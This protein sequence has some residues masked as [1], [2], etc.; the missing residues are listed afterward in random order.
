MF[1]NILHAPTPIKRWGWP[2]HGFWV[3]TQASEYKLIIAGH[4]IS[5]PSWFAGWPAGRRYGLT[6]KHPDAPPLAMSAAEKQ[7]EADQNRVWA[8]FAMLAGR[9]NWMYANNQ[10]GK[11]SWIATLPDNKAWRVGLLPFNDAGNWV[12][13]MQFY[14]WTDGPLD[15]GTGGFRY[16]AINAKGANNQNELFTPATA[17]AAYTAGDTYYRI[18]DIS[19]FGRRAVVNKSPE[20]WRSAAVIRIP[21]ATEFAAMGIDL[22]D[23]DGWYPAAVFDP[24]VDNVFSYEELGTPP[25]S[26]KLESAMV[27]ESFVVNDIDIVNNPPVFNDAIITV[28][29]EG[30]SYE[31]VMAYVPVLPEVKCKVTCQMARKAHLSDSDDTIVFYR[32]KTEITGY[33]ELIGGGIQ[34]VVSGSYRI[35]ENALATGVREIF[36]VT[37]TI[38]YGDA[39]WTASS[40]VVYEYSTNNPAS[41]YREVDG[42]YSVR[43]LVPGF[44]A[45]ETM[46]R[47]APEDSG[48]AYDFST[49]QPFTSDQGR[50]EQFGCPLM[51][52]PPLNEDATLHA[53]KWAP[54][55]LEIPQ[56][57]Y[58]RGRFI[59]AWLPSSNYAWAFNPATN[60]L[61]TLPRA[62]YR[63][64]TPI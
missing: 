40:Q 38:S 41:D 36:D 35:T 42:T 14:R 37:Q 24:V 32:T 16:F 23:A 58:Y 54:A 33:R 21:S 7:E 26:K 60:E 6:V 15:L 2:H 57:T 39:T 9:D 46:F 43:P 1:N 64:A 62:D 56:G 31:S 19:I 48:T 4:E 63:Y 5:L 51:H 10:L 47:F 49:A 27:S 29:D 3:V 52:M 45:N 8:D 22:E 25:W 61:L 12:W 50:G 55:L 53:E 11:R 44:V 18:S 28:F 17:Q 30:E 20:E 13:M 34:W 59:S